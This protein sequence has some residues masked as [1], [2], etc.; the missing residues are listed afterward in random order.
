MQQIDFS[1]YKFR[2]SGI[3]NLMVN[4]RSKSD[5]L[6]E[7]TKAYLQDVWIQEV[8]GRKKTIITIEMQKGTIVESDTMDLVQKVSGQTYFKNKE[9]LEND[10]VKGTPDIVDRPADF[11]RDIKSSWDLWTFAK[12]TKESATKDY[13]Y[14]VL[15]YMWLTGLQHGELIYGLVNTPDFIVQDELY[16]FSYKMPED[17]ALAQ[18]VNY[19]FDDI[20]GESRIKRF[21]FDFNPDDIEQIKNKVI[22]AR[23]YLKGFSL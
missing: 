5:P 22:L 1:N 19:E 12:V 9:Q 14:Q 7:T 13:Y 2:A 8:L 10:F 20:P 21:Q 6:S 4:S 15:T 3:K 16:R 18:R 11:I 23:D 17:Q